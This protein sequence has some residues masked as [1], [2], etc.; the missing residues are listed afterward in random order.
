ME[1][2]RIHEDIIAERKKPEMCLQCGKGPHM[3]FECFTKNPITTCTVPKK[4]GI[5]Q[6]QD[7]SKEDKKKNVKI[8][9]VGKEDEYVGRIIELVTDSDWDYELLK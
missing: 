4:G 9:G 6:V 7:T 3:C 1:L 8:S 5:P 2:K